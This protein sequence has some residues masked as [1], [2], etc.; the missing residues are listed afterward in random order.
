ML[1]R[2]KHILRTFPARPLRPDERAL[3][4]EWLAA[5]GDVSLVYVS[6]RRTDDPAISRRIAISLEPSS[7]FT[8]LVHTPLHEDFW[9]V[10]D[11]R[12]KT[13]FHR[14][15]TLVE[16]LNFVRP[17]HRQPTDQPTDRRGDQDRHRDGGKPGGGRRAV[18]RA[19]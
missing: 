13:K 8:F 4:A 19:K 17:V 18:R 16:A 12:R 6:E 3:V 1:V 15:D 9:I 14:F 7:A 11:A 5:A 10:L 2:E